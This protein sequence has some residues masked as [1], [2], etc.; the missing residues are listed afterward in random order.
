MAPV[1]LNGSKATQRGNARGRWARL[2]SMA[3]VERN[4]RPQLGGDSGSRP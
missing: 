1:T 4:F 2:R 3:R